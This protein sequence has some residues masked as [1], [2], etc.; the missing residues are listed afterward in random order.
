MVA[1]NIKTQCA[2]YKITVCAG[3]NQVH[4]KIY[5]EFYF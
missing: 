2:S 5:A 4:V 1:N 3:T